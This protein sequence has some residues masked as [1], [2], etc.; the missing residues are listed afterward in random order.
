MHG[1]PQ[2]LRV[3]TLSRL[4]LPSVASR[5]ARLRVHAHQRLACFAPLVMLT[6]LAASKARLL[7]LFASTASHVMLIDLTATALLAPTALSPM[8]TDLAATALLAFTALPVMLTD[9]TASTLL[10]VTA[11]SSM[12]TDLTAST[13]LDSLH[14]LRCRPCSQI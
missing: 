7:A 1:A 14:W 6:E 8:L 5:R 11:T 4:R 9:A 3:Y 10:A 2:L 13:L 12:L